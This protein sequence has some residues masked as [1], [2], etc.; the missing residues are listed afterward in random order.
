M[1]SLPGG[2]PTSS[3]WAYLGGRAGP[4]PVYYRDGTGFLV[5]LLGGHFWF[6]EIKENILVYHPSAHDHFFIVKEYIKKKESKN[7]SIFW[8]DRGK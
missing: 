3:G 7:R 1:A 6:D 8:F 5:S 2:I 4:G